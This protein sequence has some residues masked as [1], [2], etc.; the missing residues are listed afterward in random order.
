[1]IR[2]PPGSTLTDTLFPYTTLFRSD[3]GR[4]A[5]ARRQTA[6]DAA[7]RSVGHAE[8]RFAAGDIAGI[9]L[10]AAARFLHEDETACASEHAT[11]AVQL[12]SLYKEIGGG[13][14]LRDAQ[15]SQR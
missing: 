14:A 8:A 1:M 3:A 5:L 9:E 2:R 4:D 15:P 13:W 6:L 10:L 12:M 11:T 7:R